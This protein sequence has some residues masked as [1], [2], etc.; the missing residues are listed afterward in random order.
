[1]ENVERKVEITQTWGDLPNS[2]KPGWMMEIRFYR[3]ETR[4][5]TIYPRLITQ[6]HAIWMED[7]VRNNKLPNE[8]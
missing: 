1:M 3:G 2:D 8:L 7:F 4:V 6:V 5:E